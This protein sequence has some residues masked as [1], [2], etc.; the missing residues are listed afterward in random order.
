MFSNKFGEVQL[1]AGDSITEC[2][3]LLGH[4]RLDRWLGTHLQL[5]AMLLVLAVSSN[6]VNTTT[7]NRK[8][9]TTHLAERIGFSLVTA[10]H[11]V[12]SRPLSLIFAVHVL[13]FQFLLLRLRRSFRAPYMLVKLFNASTS[14]SKLQ[15]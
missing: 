6:L 3:T 8:I 14:H 5:A 12:L 1:S 13:R 2:L 10:P 11:A 15:S 9:N 4:Q 7:S